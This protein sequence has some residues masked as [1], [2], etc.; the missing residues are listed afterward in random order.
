ML[1]WLHQ[2]IHE[3]DEVF[4]GDPYPCGIEA[5]R[6]SLDALMQYLVEQHFIA[7]A[8]PARGRFR[9]GGQ[10]AALARARSG[11]ATLPPHHSL[12]ATNGPGASG[13]NGG[14]PGRLRP[15]PAAPFCRRARCRRDR[16]AQRPEQAVRSRR[17]ARR[18]SQGGA[19]RQCRRP[20]AGRQRA[21]EPH[22]L[23]QGIR[24]HA[25]KAPA[26]NPAPAAQQARIRRGE[27]Q[28]SAGAA[29]GDD[30]RRH[31][32]DQAA[33]ASPAR[34]GRRALHLRRHG[35]RARSRDRPDQCRLAPL[36]GARP[37]HHRHRS[38][39]AERSAQ[40]LSRDARSA[41]SGC[42]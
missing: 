29:D 21:R 19:V 42:R 34:Q 32:P 13:N 35:F 24:H 6:P 20:A 26:G 18:Q 14:G 5:N 16:A 38:R 33:G 1:P 3:L 9:A 23:R 12:R 40:H 17:H 10:V 8:D 28:G 22:A 11:G 36:H 41:A 27:P 15:L 39:R 30:R 4:G 25:A 2:D 7:Q 37:R 31:R